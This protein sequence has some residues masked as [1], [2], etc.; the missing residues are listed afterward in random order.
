MQGVD[1][2]VSDRS[3]SASLADDVAI[4]TGAG[5]GIGRAVAL[6]LAAEGAAVGVFARTMEEIAATA[7]LIAE[8]GGRA[9]AVQ[10]DV[11]DAAAVR[12]A[13]AQT[14][15]LFGPVTVLVNNA[16]TPGPVGRDWDVDAELWFE[17]IAVTVRGSLLL[18]QAVVPGMIAGGAGRI[19]N[20]ASTS[21][22]RAFPLA[23][24]TS[25]A[26]TALIRVT[27]GLAAQLGEYG[28][29]VFAVHPGIVR[30]RLLESYGFQIPEERFATP[31]RAGALAAQLASGRY[32]ELSGRYLGIGDDLDALVSRI[33]DIKAGEL[34]MLRMKS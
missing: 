4:V 20:I 30:T 17:C 26:K 7:Q 32:D 6:S 19:I 2:N 10:V 9:V 21:G 22:T 13:V 28:V 27:E 25:V 23:T 34:Y 16:G 8:A 1:V 29:A 5:R 31:E 11:T 33:A 24:A 14:V 15:S 3:I 18:S 12:A